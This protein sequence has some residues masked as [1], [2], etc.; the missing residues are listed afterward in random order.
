M[1]LGWSQDVNR[2]YFGVIQR[3]LDPVKDLSAKR[4]RNNPGAGSV[5]I[6]N[7]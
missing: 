6:I 7:A 5:R 4:L 1:M 3:F 2:G